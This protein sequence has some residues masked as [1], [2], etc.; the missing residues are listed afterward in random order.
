[1]FAKNGGTLNGDNGDIAAD[2]FHK[3][4]DDHKL[5]KNLGF[6]SFRLSFSWPRLSPDGS[7]KIL[8]SG[9]DHYTACS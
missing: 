8:Q 1:M 3:F 2:H 7:N 6:Q 4:P 9:L 5:A